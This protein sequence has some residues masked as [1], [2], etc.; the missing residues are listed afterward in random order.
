M[1]SL[2]EI[3]NRVKSVKSTQKIT[4]AM[5]LVAAAKL[6][7]AQDAVTAARPYSVKMREV[8][9]SLV[10]DVDPESN[11][12]FQA[13][14]TPRKALILPMT[15]D[16]GLCGGFNATLLRRTEHFLRTNA[17]AYDEIGVSAVG[18]K[19]RVYFRNRELPN[20]VNTEEMELKPDGESAIKLAEA[21]VQQFLET[22]VDEVYIVF[23]E[24][25][26]AL[27]QEVVIEQLLP[28]S[29]ETF[30][31]DST[32][33]E[34]L[35]GGSAGDSMIERI[36]EPSKERLLEALLPRYIESQILRA[37][38]ESEA[39]EQGAR[40]TAMDSATNNAKDLI[41]SLTLQMNRARQAIITTELMEI[42]SGAEALK[43]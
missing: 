13:E 8:I 4:R 28:L 19:G 18:R 22:E 14:E 23:N 6:K 10:A 33:L 12:L 41:D 37:L 40:M 34:E 11:P 2:K 5:K 9:A 3:R 21:L 42:T 16:R 20:Y 17:E 26:S 43:G 25:K 15:S 1:P 36:F 35:R 29:P 27:T 24:F 31:S 32:E 30:A 39:S 7:R 38:L